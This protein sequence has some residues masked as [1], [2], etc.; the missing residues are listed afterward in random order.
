MPDRGPCLDCATQ[1]WGK[2]RGE[3]VRSLP[4]RCCDLPCNPVTLRPSLRGGE[5]GETAAFV[6]KEVADHTTWT[7]AFL[8]PAY[9][10]CF[11]RWKESFGGGTDSLA[12]MCLLPWSV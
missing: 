5:A 3:V 12:D 2:D 11:P 6:N 1:S 4:V 9:R 10:D 8:H 7:P